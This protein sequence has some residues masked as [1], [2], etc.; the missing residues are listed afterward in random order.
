MCDNRVVIIR[1]V[2]HYTSMFLQFTYIPFIGIMLY[3]AASTEEVEEIVLAKVF[4]E[5]EHMEI[6]K[7]D[8][9]VTSLDGEIE[10]PHRG[11]T[12]VARKA[13]S[14]MGSIVSHRLRE[15]VMEKPYGEKLSRLICNDLARKRRIKSI[16]IFITLKK[17][18]SD[19]FVDL[20]FI[21]QANVKPLLIVDR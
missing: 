12:K 10:G 9:K 6:V 18:C 2:C 4:F 17:V 8:L 15:E 21:S 5:I 7:V 14:F 19:P 3:Y 13:R 16:A 20:A 1:L 11:G